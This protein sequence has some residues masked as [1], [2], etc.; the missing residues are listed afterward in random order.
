VAIED[1]DANVL[2]RGE[3]QILGKPAETVT[4]I[5][6]SDDSDVCHGQKRGVQEF[7]QVIA[8]VLFG[9]HFD[10]HELS[11][12]IHAKSLGICQNSSTRT[13]AHERKTRT[14]WD[15]NG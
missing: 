2:P 13:T 3:S 10:R 9:P 11:N 6:D 15:Q 1:D 7:N 12:A 14:G 4:V 5:D 8:V